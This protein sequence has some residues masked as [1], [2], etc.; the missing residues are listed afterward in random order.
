LFLHVMLYRQEKHPQTPSIPQL[1]W[2]ID[3]HRPIYHHTAQH[4]R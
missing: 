2:V 3:T 4:G 1:M